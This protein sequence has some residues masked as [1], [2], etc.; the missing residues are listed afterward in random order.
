[1]EQWRNH[2]Q[3]GTHDE[4]R[5]PRHHQFGHVATHVASISARIWQDELPHENRAE[6]RVIH[7]GWLLSGT[8]HAD[9]LPVG[10]PG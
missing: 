9:R 10:E 2:E 6:F 8:M 5:Q 1:M 3:V 4:K 7:P